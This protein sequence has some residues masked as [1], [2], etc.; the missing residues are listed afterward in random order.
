MFSRRE[1][2]N[3]TALEVREIFKEP[4]VKMEKCGLCGS[5]V[6][7]N[8]YLISENGLQMLI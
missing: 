2:I 4:S 5:T 1:Q 3:K 8:G 6:S 7:L